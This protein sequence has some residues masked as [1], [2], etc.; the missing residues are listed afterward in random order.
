[1]VFTEFS[2]KKK[3]LGSNKRHLFMSAEQ[4]ICLLLSATSFFRLKSLTSRLGN[5]GALLTCHVSLG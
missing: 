1:L 4:G 3:E 2:V 5:G